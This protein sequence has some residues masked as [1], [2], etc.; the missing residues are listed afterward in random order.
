VL[1]GTS[2]RLPMG[3]IAINKTPTSSFDAGT[4]IGDAIVIFF[5]PLI[6]NVPVITHEAVSRSMISAVISIFILKN[7]LLYPTLSIRFRDKAREAVAHV[8]GGSSPIAN[9]LA[10]FLLLFA[11]ADLRGAFNGFSHPFSFIGLAFLTFGTFVYGL[12]VFALNTR[13]TQRTFLLGALSYGLCAF[14][15]ANFAGHFLGVVANS[16][17]EEAGPNK[18]LSW[19]GIT[20]ER[21]VFPFSGG[22]NNFGIMA[23]MCFV[24]WALQ[25]SAARTLVKKLFALGLA[26]VGLCGVV[27]TD[28]RG[29]FLVAALAISLS[30]AGSRFAGVRNRLKWL[31]Y[32]LPLVP[33]ILIG[34]I[35]SISYLGLA[36]LFQREGQFALRLGLASGRDVIWKAVLHTFT[37]FDPIQIIG[38]GT[39][40]Q[41]TSGAS[42]EFSWVFLQIGGL[43]AASV[44]NATLQVLVDVG[45]V[46]LIVWII[47]WTRVFVGLQTCLAISANCPR[48]RMLVG[49]ILVM[50]FSGFTEAGGTVYQADSFGIFL[51][52]LAA[53]VGYDYKSE[54]G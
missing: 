51:V 26:G 29:M 23:C 9:V 17:L 54:D 18:M 22:L 20:K 38:Y 3:T 25:F 42:K 1:L 40:G 7:L 53:L 11:L 48:R 16:G 24:A 5:L 14:V 4:P 43:T 6:L 12:T 34:M 35:E 36:D 39:Y 30:V 10:L 47:L 19:V 27:L 32:A 50:M 41:I 46:G 33:L 49:L 13:T 2:K 31:P 28:T 15:L 37:S 8:L 21:I 44:H 52:L 45:Y